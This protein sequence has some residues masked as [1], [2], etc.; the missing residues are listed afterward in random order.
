MNEAKVFVAGA[1]NGFRR[2]S[3]HPA[4]AGRRRHLLFA[5]Y[6]SAIPSICDRGHSPRAASAQ[7]SAAKLQRRWPDG[8]VQR[9]HREPATRPLHRLPKRLPVRGTEAPPS[10]R[11]CARAQR[12]GRTLSPAKHAMTTRRQ[13]MDSKRALP[14]LWCGPRISFSASCIP[15]SSGV[16]SGTPRISGKGSSA[17]APAVDPGQ[18]QSYSRRSA[19]SADART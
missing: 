17:L 19:A 14:Q 8:H 2:R 5:P 10:L 11:C 13:S 18:T 7:F 15:A 9:S 1:G 12:I 4:T 16:T 3:L 6:G